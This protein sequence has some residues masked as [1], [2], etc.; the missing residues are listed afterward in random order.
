MGGMYPQYSYQQYQQYPSQI[1]R[2]GYNGDMS[3]GSDGWA[4]RN[5]LQRL[6]LH[7]YAMPMTK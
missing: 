4:R 5:M 2:S 1:L 6:P 7:P 3:F